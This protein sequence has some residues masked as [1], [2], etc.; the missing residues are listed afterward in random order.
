MER[1]YN[2]ELTESEIEYLISC[3][4]ALL[5]NIPE[6]SLTTYCDFTKDQIIEFS[7]RLR[8]QERQIESS[9]KNEC[10]SPSLQAKIQLLE[11]RGYVILLK[12]D[13]E[14][15]SKNKTIVIS[16]PQSDFIYRI[17]TDS[18]TTSLLT[19]LEQIQE[20]D[21]SSSHC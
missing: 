15:S 10:L 12:W 2:I 6:K 16:N 9:D 18:F 21:A 20:Q 3:G 1:K 17:D 4:S 5:Q 11:D 13:G 19:A 14:R 8:N 7:G